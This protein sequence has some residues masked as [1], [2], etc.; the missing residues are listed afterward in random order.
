M[1]ATRSVLTWLDDVRFAVRRLR[2]RVSVTML[3]ITILALGLG[4]NA[5]IVSVAHALL[6]RPLPFPNGDR[7]V[8][9]RSDVAGA[10]GRIAIREYRA[11]LAD[12]HLLEAV[13]PFHPT[14]Y[15]LA[16][17]GATPEAVTG[18]T[19]TSNLLRVLGV[20]PVVGATWPTSLDLTRQ[21]TVVLGHGLWRRAFG[22]DPSI[23]GKSVR[24][25]GYDYHVV[26]VAPEGADFPERTD[27]YRAMTEYNADDARRML[28]LGLVRR[29]VT[30]AQVRAELG[31]L[32]GKLART[33]PDSNTGV[34]LHAD[35]LR[36]AVIGDSR[37]FMWLLV[38]GALVVLTLTCANA[39][40][41]MLA[42][43]LDRQG[44]LSVRLA[45][46]AS[47]A[48][49]LRELVAEHLLLGLAG[50]LLGLAL[51]Q[52]VLG[53]LLSQFEFKLPV[54]MGVRLSWP[55][56][57]GTVIA[58]L[59][60]GVVSAIPPALRLVGVPA[61]DGL[62]SIGRSAGSGPATRL[63]R[64]LVVGQ[65]AL[66]MLLL[67]TAGL[68]AR[69]VG[70]L[71]GAPMGFDAQNVFTV[72]VD[73]PWVRYPD[74]A[75]TSEFYRR[76]TDEIRR[77]PGVASAAIN[78]NLPLATLPDAVS[79]TFFVE[80]QPARRRGEQPFAV[81][82]QVGPGYFETMRIRFRRGRDIGSHDLPD[83]MPVAVVGARLAAQFWPNADPIGK[84]L[85]LEGTA[86]RTGGAGPLS[87]TIEMP[88]LTVVGVAD[89]VRH[90]HVRARPGFDVYL[91][92]TQHFT[93][94][95]YIVVRSTLPAETLAR[96]VPAAVR[97]IDPEQSVFAS[98]PMTAIVDQTIWQAR[99]A[100]TLGVG[101]A[102]LALVLAAAGLHAIVSQSVSRRTREMG[103]R[104]AIGATP[105]D[106]GGI[107]AR[108]TFRLV[109]AGVGLGLAGSLAMGRAAGALLYD[110]SAWDPLTHLAA[111]TFLA[112]GA[113]IAA[114]SPA[115]RAARISPLTALRQP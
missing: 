105:R 36:D 9:I 27:V 52:G 79:R 14:Q 103:L 21:Y 97:R 82:Q 20:E 54:W 112:L 2:R 55:I 94:D 102:L 74:T 84:R 25:D 23:V 37:P 114:L 28:L 68:L 95:A 96:V 63:Q 26:G 48:R 16:Q 34:A 110:V 77:L 67:A 56:A 64:W 98:R 62:K 85:R 35:G 3:V 69:S 12:S 11:L 107:I 32:S 57:I 39:G 1:S 38:G 30:L 22:G 100:G 49:L 51:A 70:R 81:V 75:T 59:M 113:A 78:Q 4:A 50:S 104:L 19:T 106:V 5:A 44:D 88:W 61:V 13:A 7:L 10:P 80:G 43:A 8:M 72:R 89:D 17:L 66:T 15:N 86:L 31:A 40:G 109:I 83:S 42:R 91:P 93:G 90:E 53:V 46:G 111:A 71:L 24:L 41:L 6:W 108:E 115:R 101:F 73:P 92:Y 65:I 29:G 60:C 47:Q 58:G 33:Y 87:A 45:L 99:L 18:T 76:V